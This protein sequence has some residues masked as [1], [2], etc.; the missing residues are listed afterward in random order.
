MKKTFYIGP[1]GTGKTESLIRKVEELMKQGVDPKEIAY[2][3]FTNI[4]ADEAKNSAIKAFPN[5]PEKKFENFKTLHSLCYAHVPELRDNLMTDADYASM[6]A[7]IPINY[8]ILNT[9]LF[10]KHQLTKKVI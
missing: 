9:A 2:I 3:S 10:G 4:A 5:V 8:Q 6:G 1:P 7:V